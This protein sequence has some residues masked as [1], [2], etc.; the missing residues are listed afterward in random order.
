MNFAMD[1]LGLKEAKLRRVPTETA[2]RAEFFLYLK[3]NFP[4]SFKPKVAIAKFIG[5]MQKKE[6]GIM[7]S[8][9]DAMPL[10][11]LDNLLKLFSRAGNRQ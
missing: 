6:L 5:K 7:K 1:T 8:G 4:I 2:N 9:L 11:L 10:F 3:R